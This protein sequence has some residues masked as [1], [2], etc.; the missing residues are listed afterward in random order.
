[1]EENNS[2]YADYTFLFLRDTTSFLLAVLEIINTFGSHSGISIN[3]G[4]SLLFYLHPSSL[5]P[6]TNTSLA[7]IAEFKY[8]GV[9]VVGSL[10]S[11]LQGELFLS[12][13]QAYFWASILVTVR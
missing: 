1:M 11:Y 8:L 3:W 6:N 13:F 7:W 2:L 12:I 10:S 4:E 5:C 9:R